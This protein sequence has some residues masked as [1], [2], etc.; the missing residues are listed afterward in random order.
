MEQFYSWVIGNKDIIKIF[1]G[2]VIGLIC[3]F[4]VARTDRLFRISFHKGIRYF[5]NA[6]LFY[7]IAFIVR[8]VFGALCLYNLIPRNYYPP[9]SLIFEF[10]LIMAGFFLFYSLIWKKIEA[11]K[12]DYTSSLLNSKILIFY[13]M[14]IV[15]SFI[16]YIWQSYY[17]LFI[18]Q[19]ILF[20]F[21][22]AISYNNYRKN[23]SK[24]KFLKFYFTAM[25]LALFAWILNAV[26]ALYFEWNKGLLTDVY[27]LNIL[28]F[29]LFL[30]GVVKLTK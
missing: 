6:F 14:A 4:I 17:L 30:Y 16:D 26:V 12:E 9:A 25:I 3:F 23:G 5:R 24:H 10:F 19:I 13:V 27:I 21:A 8:Y 20:I 18:S 1:Y 15:I 22:S 28:F 7:G 29:I 11:V 2:L